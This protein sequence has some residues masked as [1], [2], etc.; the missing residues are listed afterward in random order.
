MFNKSPNSV[1]SIDAIDAIDVWDDA[2]M[3]WDDAEMAWD[4]ALVSGTEMEWGGH[5]SNSESAESAQ[6]E[7]PR[8]MTSP[9]SQEQQA[10][11]LSDASV[12]SDWFAYWDTASQ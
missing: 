12:A 3:A 9:Q 10:M 6:C 8:L 2:E 4:D 7:P 11:D 1:A 5:L